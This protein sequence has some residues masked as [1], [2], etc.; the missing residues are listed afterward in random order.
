MHLYVPGSTHLFLYSFL[1]VGFLAQLP[2]VGTVPASQ[3]MC[4]MEPAS[5]REDSQQTNNHMPNFA[6]KID[7][8]KRS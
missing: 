2:C 8:V 4:L 5:R 1:Q 7:G 6:I 3:R